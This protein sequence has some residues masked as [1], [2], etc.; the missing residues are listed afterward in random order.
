MSKNLFK[1]PFGVQAQSLMRGS[2]KKKMKER[3]V[4]TYKASGVTIEQM[5][6]VINNK[7]D[8]GVVKV[9][10]QAITLY[11][12]SADPLFF[13]YSDLMTAG[14]LNVEQLPKQNELVS[15]CLR[16]CAFPVAIGYVMDLSVS[17]RMAKKGRAVTIIHYINDSL[18]EYGT[19]EVPFTF[20]SSG[21]E[22]T[23][24][25]IETAQEPATT[26]TTTTIK[27]PVEEMDDIVHKSFMGAIKHGVPDSELPIVLK[28]FFNK[29][30]L[31]YAPAGTHEINVQRS[32]YK[33]VGKLITVMRK[34]GLVEM[35]EPKPGNI[36][37]TKIFRNRPEYKEFELGDVVGNH[38]QEE[39][40]V[41]DSTPYG[42]S[43]QAFVPIRSVVD[44]YQVPVNLL[45]AVEGKTTVPKKRYYNDKDVKEII[46]EYIKS[47]GLDDPNNRAN[48]IPD[49][50]A[51]S[52]LPSSARKAASISKNN[53][54]VAAKEKLQKFIE[55][56]SKFKQIEVVG[57][58][59]AN[60]YVLEVTGLDIFAIP[61]KE[62]AKEGQKIF[63][64]S[65]TVTPVGGTSKNFII[66]IQ[67][68]DTDR[69]ASYI[70]QKYN[71]PPQY[72]FT[73]MTLAA[74]KK[75]GK[76]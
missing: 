41:A 48:I 7:K 68:N 24:A 63:A 55:I 18:W 14:I 40:E 3:L 49:S 20:E 9:Q 47:A 2:D 44:V 56:T 60:K 34:K 76:K 46:I 6:E 72:V 23:E 8:L 5:D 15:I 57:K 32:S 10:Q 66:R 35:T 65:T 4:Q 71:V 13:D 73:D 36:S 67:G 62:F 19:K 64:A 17:D 70:Q 61:P 45:L 16:G 52:L 39:E 22:P 69:V 31:F 33:K 74:S 21:G 30:M 11:C 12:Q 43:E 37:I 54:Y 75:K 51:S 29:Y 50:L 1:K 38:K 53:F 59:I 58:K 26:T 27:I 25:T 28:T 42:Q